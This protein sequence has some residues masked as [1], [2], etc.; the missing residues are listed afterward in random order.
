MVVF[1]D[2][3]TEGIRK[4]FEEWDPKRS[5]LKNVLFQMPTGTGKTTVFSETVRKA[6]LKNKFVLMV[7]HRHSE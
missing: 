3:Q 1:R 4:I 5:N 7:V 2:Y 6:H